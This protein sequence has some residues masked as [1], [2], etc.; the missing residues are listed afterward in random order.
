MEEWQMS[1]L[2][3]Y[4]AGYVGIESSQQ[5][6]NRGRSRRYGGRSQEAGEEGQHLIDLPLRTS[7]PLWKY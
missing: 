3:L 4:Q 2:G 6:C 5:R 1:Y 7:R